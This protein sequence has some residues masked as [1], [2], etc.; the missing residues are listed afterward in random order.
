MCEATAVGG[1]EMVSGERLRAALAGI[2]IV[3]VLALVIAPRADAAAPEGT[4]I[5]KIQH[6]VMIMQENRSFDSYFGTYPGANGIPAGVCVPDPA[7][8]GCVQPFHNS[9]ERNF[10]GPH[11]NN[12]AFKDIDGGRMDGFLKTA[13]EGEKCH[14]TGSG[15]SPCR[16]AE[17]GTSCG[18]VMGYHDAREIPNYWSYAQNYVLQDKL[19]ESAASSSLYEH[20]YVV[21]AWAALCP[22]GGAN[23]L[24]C[25]SSV[26][27]PELNH[28]PHAWT[29]IT[30]LLH[31]A[32]VSWRYYVFEGTEPDCESDE[33]ITCAPVQQGPTTPG[34]WNPLADFTDVKEDGQLEDIQ[35][36]TNFYS[37]VQ[38][39]SACGLPNV[40]W[41]VPKYKVSEH[42][43]A[44]V[45]EGQTYVTTLINSI[46]RSP[47]W[48]ST[49]IFLS[50]DDWGGLYD[51]VLPP[52]IDENG[53]GLRVPALV[54]SPYAKAGYIDH[55]QLSHDAYL[56]FIEDDFLEGAR[57]NPA[58]DGRPD[59]RPDVREEAPGLGDMVNDFNFD[60]TPRPPL[61]LSAHPAPGLPSQP[62]GSQRPPALETDVASPVTRTSATLNATVNPDGAA[63]S[64]C[65]F[66]YGISTSYEAS[67][68]CSSLPGSG[69][70]PV[71]VSAAVAGLAA[72]TTYH[73]RIVATNAAGTSF[74]PDLPFT[75][76]SRPPAVETGSPSS[77]TQT[78]ATLNATVDPENA[79]VNECR[80]EYGTS[81]S[82]EASVPC[83]S[84]PGSGSS[85]VPVSAVVSGLRA[86]T[87][88]HFRI[89]A[90]SGGGTGY[91]ADQEFT[92]LPNAPTVTKVQPD[93]GLAQGGT[94]V[95]ISGT[96][97]TKV[98]AV[99]FGA[100][101][102]S[103]VTVNSPT[104]IS[105]VAP[106]GT[107]IV[108]VT[109]TNTGGASP[110]NPLDQF[111]YVPPGPP[112]IVKRIEP[113]TGTSAGGTAVTVTGKGF[114][115]VTA[116]TFGTT[117]AG[118][119]T[120]NSPTSILAVSPAEP[121]GTVPL[122]VTTPNGTSA[123]SAKANFTFLEAGSALGEIGPLALAGAL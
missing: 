4:G 44:P 10:G 30:Y 27:G 80:F 98:L 36:L 105:A 66:E 71:P 62:P 68:P 37:A 60:Q 121:A 1:A 11:G 96:N 91:G 47:C 114:S 82:Y 25:V 120:V 20:L 70:S 53:Y 24:E 115:G 118:S 23:P 85:P 113:A 54:I 77:V 42:P 109:V 93:A 99:T 52:V 89:L 51:H 58:T 64:N 90:T 33:A 69:S 13:E 28:R 61:L 43:A 63:V 75:T 19:F 16:H 72:N 50:W 3:V 67:V 55:Q 83:G 48:S 59:S 73:V 26:E 112:P 106:A 22:N 95:A 14:G 76:A 119:F 111:T 102:A 100:Q 12:A 78:S 57:L 122:S 7:N 108:D 5:H 56:K 9:S 110:V 39:Q 8:G 117:A 41:I 104:S 87:T 21:S 49:A 97:F 6:V 79:L 88:Y 103:A 32:G 17:A 31:R 81:S 15:C 107:G 74:G 40:A 86:D 35:S 123:S 29:D 18:E 101:E 94:A 116:V 2:V 34:I 45:D 46:M 38:D 84:L 92:T 65:H